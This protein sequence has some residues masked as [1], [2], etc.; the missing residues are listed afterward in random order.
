MDNASTTRRDGRQDGRRNALWGLGL[1]SMGALAACA[2]QAAPPADTRA[3]DEAAI[4]KLENEWIQAMQTK[5]V[6]AWT[7]YYADDAIVMP[8]G[9]PPATTREAIAKAIAGVLSLPG[10]T[11]SGQAGKVEIARSGDLAYVQGSYDVAFRDRRGKTMREHGKYLN[12]WRKQ[13][14]GGW[15][16]V[17]DM[18][19]PDSQG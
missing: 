11:I 1:A 16:C 4:R 18:W 2:P 5:Q 12:V 17:I 7:A 19:S 9:E 13:A 8:P 3:A 15:K 6:A 14:D 10:L